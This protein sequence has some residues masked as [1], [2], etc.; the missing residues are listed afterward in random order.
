MSAFIGEEVCDVL[1]DSINH[2]VHYNIGE[3]ETFDY[4]VDKLTLQEFCGYIKGNILKYVSRE[5]YK[6][7]LNDLRK[8]QWYLNKYIERMEKL[9]NE[10]V[11][12]AECRGCTSTKRT[13]KSGIIVQEQL[14]PEMSREE[15]NNENM[16][17]QREREIRWK[18]AMKREV[19]TLER[20]YVRDGI[21][22]R[23]LGPNSTSVFQGFH[24]PAGE[25]L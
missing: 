6:G 25:S 24:Q 8:A 16:T 3:I 9:E 5:R 4:I 22:I 2:P 15:K 11:P 23:H 1:N 19:G 10:P 17:E 13:D 7:G 20:T 12:T 18:D 21:T 14:K